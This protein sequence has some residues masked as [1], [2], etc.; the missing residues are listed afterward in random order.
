MPIREG[1]FADL[2]M[3][4]SVSPLRM[5]AKPYLPLLPLVA[6]LG[7][8]VSLLDG[9]GVGTLVP[10]AATMLAGDA[11]AQVGQP[12][13][14]GLVFRLAGTIPEASRVTVLG[15]MALALLVLRGA[16]QA[17]NN[18]LI[19]F[20][21]SRFV[22]DL[23]NAMAER[24]TGVEFAFFLRE[25]TAR[26]I[27]VFTAFSWSVG[28]AL[29]SVLAMIPALTGMAV[30]GALL[31]WLDWRLFLVVL[32][33]AVLI[34]GVLVLLQRRQDHFDT[35]S[36][37]HVKEQGARMI[38]MVTA[39]R[40]TRVFGQEERERTRFAV[41]CQRVFRA[42]FAWYAVG[43]AIMPVVSAAMAAVFVLVLVIGWQLQVP[44]P[45]LIAYV[46]LLARVEPYAAA[47]GQ[48]RSGISGVTGRVREVE[49]LLG[50]EPEPE[51][52]GE[53]CAALDAPVR[54]AGVRYAYPNGAEALH[55]VDFSIEPGVAT[56]LIGHSGAG[57]STIV[58]LLCRLVE[59]T[60]GAILLGDRPVAALDKRDW[61]TRIAVAGQDVLLID[62]SVAENIGYGC[63]GASR[64]EIEDVAAVAGA[65]AFIAAL[66]GGYDA[67]VGYEG[68]NL[69]GGQRQ[70]IGL[71]RALLRRPDLLILDEATNAVDAL[72]EAEIM[73]LLGEHRHFRTALVISHRHSTLAACTNGIVVEQGRVVE[74][75]PLQSLAYLRSM[76]GETV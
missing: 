27:Q 41:V 47:V 54:F 43:A 20:I 61:R 75:G 16:V 55:G 38:A 13:P 22:R 57:K 51:S 60:A 10:L 9:L 68:S 66:P 56:A 48:A 35:V 12:G 45:A 70:R 67:P 26:L 34:R 52:K 1:T 73:R 63:P 74:A 19:A 64:A 25:D 32:A 62:G 30:V 69:S 18:V 31:A 23:H 15:G 65:A 50:Q 44:A 3:A 4:K 14:I 40:T 37:G 6:G 71:A 5:V 28:D 58:N 46:I 17:G 76:T 42:G 21:Q 7:V 11:Q 29:R 49:W 2:T 59:P 72:S 24:L 33:C 53:P 36:T 39:M 8:L